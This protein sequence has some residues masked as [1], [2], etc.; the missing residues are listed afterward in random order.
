MPLTRKP[1]DNLEGSIEALQNVQSFLS[2]ASENI[3]NKETKEMLDNELININNTLKN[4]KDLT[5]KLK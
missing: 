3:E 4:I 2:G 1:K 5:S